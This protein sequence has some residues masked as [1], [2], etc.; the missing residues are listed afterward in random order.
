[1]ALEKENNKKGKGIAEPNLYILHCF[2]NIKLTY[3]SNVWDQ[4][5]AFSNPY[6]RWPD[7]EFDK[8]VNFN[9]AA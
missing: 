4:S 6:V 5:D 7:Y 1:M 3:L 8:K 9:K 2:F